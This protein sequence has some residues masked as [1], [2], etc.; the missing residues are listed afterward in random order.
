MVRELVFLDAAFRKDPRA[1]M[2]AGGHEEVFDASGVSMDLLR[3]DH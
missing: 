1:G 3:R 2:F